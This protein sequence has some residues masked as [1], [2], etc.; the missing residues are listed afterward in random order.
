M[1]ESSGRLATQ[2]TASVWMGW[3]AKRDAPMKEYN[4]A[5]FAGISGLSSD[6]NFTLV[7]NT[8]IEMHA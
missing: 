3:A 8:N 5:L 2:V 1:N 4:L 6:I 7:R